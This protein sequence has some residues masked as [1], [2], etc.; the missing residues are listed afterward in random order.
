LAIAGAVAGIAVMLYFVGAVTI[1]ARLRAAGLP[2]DIATEH[3]PR[4]EVIALGV[5]GV[6]AIVALLGLF[7]A[8]LYAL[9]LTATYLVLLLAWLREE[10]YIPG[11]GSSRPSMQAA[12]REQNLLDACASGVRTLGLGPF[13]LLTLLGA[14]AV[15]VSAFASWHVFAGTIAVVAVAGV[16]LRYLHQRGAH[17]PRSTWILMV[18]ILLAA[19][20]SGTAWQI[21]PT[22]YIQTVTVVP[23]P[24]AGGVAIDYLNK[25]KG[26]PLP[27]LGE[28]SAYVYVAEIINVK[29]DRDRPGRLTW[30]YTHRIL[31]LRRDRVRLVFPAEK[32][33]LVPDV[34]SP[35]TTFWHAIH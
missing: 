10:T 28:T 22:L 5:R 35:A 21:Q 6:I 31:E 34:P 20:A 23:K 4:A 13:R 12:L 15:I 18:I 9:I 2:A 1:W 24:K 7:A 25:L 16:T 27:Y 8:A 19:G 32:G 3:Y 30:T 17:Q 11:T 33:Y 14:S 26:A 29:P